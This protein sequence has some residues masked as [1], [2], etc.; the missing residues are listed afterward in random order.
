MCEGVG[1]EDIREFR[2]ILLV[3][4]N[5]EWK[6]V[7]NIQEMASSS[8]NNPTLVL[9]GS[10]PLR[11]S[12]SYKLIVNLY[13]RDKTT[14]QREL[15]FHT[16]RPPGGSSSTGKNCFVF[17][18][19]GQAVI[20]DFTFRCEG[21]IDED[22]PLHYQFSLSSPVGM[23]FYQTGPSPNATV[24]LPLG[25]SRN[26][27]S[28]SV[29]VTITDSYGAGVQTAVNVKVSFDLLCSERTSNAK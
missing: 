22:F 26:N 24:R 13:M 17:P 1:C 8:L 15:L 2:W 4:E 27:Y 29:T 14:E 9:S 23:V 20:D 28:L 12:T 3:Q 7:D 16:N 11:S 18:Q 10:P 19:E 6:E 5:H 21:Y 25:D